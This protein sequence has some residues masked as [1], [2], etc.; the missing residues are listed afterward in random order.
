MSPRARK[1]RTARRTL[2]SSERGVSWRSGDNPSI[3][4]E[5]LSRTQRALFAT[6][7]TGVVQQDRTKACRKVRLFRAQQPEHGR[8]LLP[9]LQSLKCPEDN[10][11]L[12]AEF[13]RSDC[14]LRARLIWRSAESRW[15]SRVARN[16]KIA[17]HQRIHLCSLKTV[18]CLSR[19][20]DDW[21]IVIEGS[22]QHHRHF[23]ELLELPNQPPVAWI[24]F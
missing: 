17:Q 19:P 20:A 16:Q 6:N 5:S 24:R 8:P 13:A 1:A 15:I 2:N 21:L 23:G 7:A 22:I 12:A 11:D 9:F 14:T 3:P 18:Q 10:R 4:R